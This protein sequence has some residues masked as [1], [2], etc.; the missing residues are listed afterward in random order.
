[1]SHETL[2]GCIGIRA[3]RVVG[4]LVEYV[5]GFKFHCT[6]ALSL[7]KKSPDLGKVSVKFGKIRNERTHIQG[8]RVTKRRM[9]LKN[10]A[11]RKAE[12]YLDMVF[13]L[14][15]THVHKRPYAA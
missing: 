14:F 8:M 1:M 10:E 13:C 3:Y 9:L 15:N 4:L 7:K 11:Q 2:L 6:S 12:I 5:Y